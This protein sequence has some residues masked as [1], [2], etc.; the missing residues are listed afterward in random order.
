MNQEDIKKIMDNALDVDY[1]IDLLNSEKQG[2]IDKIIPVEV[3]AE[4]E[5]VEEEFAPKLEQLE[6]LKKTN[7]KIA[8]GMLEQF[9]AENPVGKEKMKIKSQLGTWTIEQGEP[10]WNTAA[11]DGYALEHPEIL[12]MRKEGKPKTR[13]TKNR[14]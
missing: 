5:S 7:R 11:L 1:R 9:L 10:E 6:E 14:M 3:Q 8:D 13:L 4:I 12:W 2:L